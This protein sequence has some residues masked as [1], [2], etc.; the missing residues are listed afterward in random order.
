MRTCCDDMHAEKI[1]SQGLRPVELDAQKRKAIFLKRSSLNE[2]KAQSILVL[3][4]GGLM[5]WVREKVLVRL[6]RYHQ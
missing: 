3:R 5:V 1:E 2:T 4:R 6:R